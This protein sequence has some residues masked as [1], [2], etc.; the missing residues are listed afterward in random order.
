MIFTTNWLSEIFTDNQ[1]NV[2]DSKEINEVST[3]SRS[4]ADNSLFIP[5]VG[6]NFDGHQFSEQAVENGAGALIWDKSKKVPDSLPEDF[7]IFFVADTLNALQELAANYRNEINP[8]VVG[9]TGSN[10]KTTTKD[11]ITTVVKTTYRTHYTNGNF[12]NHI[13]LPLTI[14]SMDRET[15]VLILEMGMSNFGEIDLLSKIARPDYAIITN[16]GESHIEFLGSREGIAKAKLEIVNGMKEDGVLIVDGDEALLQN[17]Q[18]PQKIIKNGFLKTNDNVLSNVS[19]TPK[20]TVFKL[21]DE[22]TYKVPL[23][24]KHH[25][26]NASFALTIG[27]QL[28][29][30]PETSN[31]ALQN[32][33][34]TGM[35]FELIKGKHD[36]SIIN[37]AYNA[38]PTSM[39]ASIEVVKQLSGF[40]QKVLVLGD[41]LE[42]GDH[43]E[44][45]HRSIAEAITP[46]ITALFT[47]G[48]KAE[49][50]CEEVDKTESS[51]ECS[52]FTSKEELAESLHSYLTKDTLLLFKA[53]RG[54]KFETIIE[55]IQNLTEEN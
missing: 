21:S 9:V 8:I 40:K 35:R 15:E 50:I 37:D 55:D 19:I 24:G 33:E 3:D 48:D 13:G 10:G 11:L 42:L 47:F 22:L 6:E 38:S 17:L 44:Q 34:L 25:A 18:F 29:I 52:H 46:P 31:D 49:I 23:L 27:E 32:L 1:G 2:Q 4:K 12:N 16:I 36:A 43:A 39:I 45:L 41:I 53:S 5:L 51:I 14:L 54:L 30:P 26:K 20:E 7:P 28:N